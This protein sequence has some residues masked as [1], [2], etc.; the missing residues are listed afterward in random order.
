MVG[1]KAAKSLYHKGS[2]A[3][4]TL[5][6]SSQADKIKG[7]HGNDVLIG[8]GG[9]DMLTGGRGADTFKY[10]SFSD[11]RGARL[12]LI[13]DFDAREGDKVDLR[14]LGTATLQPSYNAALSTLQAVF[15]YDA[16][17]NRTTL[18]YYQGSSTPVFQVQFKGEVRY[19]A[20]A[21]LGIVRPVG[22]T[23]QGD[24]LT[25]TA[26]NDV[27]DLLG[28]NDTYDGLAGNDTIRGGGGN[29][30]LKGGDNNDTIFG[31]A[32]NDTIVG[33]RHGDDLY[34]GTGADRFVHQ[35][36]ADSAPFLDSSP[37]IDRIYD[38]NSAEGDKIDLTALA[39]NGFYLGDSFRLDLFTTG[40]GQIILTD[41]GDGTYLLRIFLPGDV[42]EDM[43]VVLNTR[44]TASDFLG[45]ENAPPP[46]PTEGDDNLTGTSGND[47][48][49]LL[50]GNDTYDGLAGNDDIRGGSG[51]DVLSGDD[52]NDAI[53]GGDDVDRLYGGNG[54]DT[55]FGDDPRTTGNGADLLDGGAGNDQLN[56]WYGD[57]TLLGG[58][59]DDDLFG[60]EGSDVLTGGAGADT[61]SFN[62]LNDAGD[63]DTVT[64]F[65]RAEGDKIDTWASR[66]DRFQNL[67]WVLVDGAFSQAADA[68]HTAG[69]IVQVANS[70][71]TY[72]LSFYYSN[73][74][75]SSF[76]VVVNTKLAP[77][78]FQ[79]EGWVQY[80]ANPT[81]GADSFIGFN[82]D[83]QI[84][85]LGGDDT[86][87][88][89]SGV[90]QING[91]A[92]NDTLRAGGPIGT[93]IGGSRIDGGSGNDLLTAG[94]GQDTLSGGDDADTLNGGGGDDALDGGNGSDKLYGDDGDDT[95][96]GGDR[97]TSSSAD[98]ADLLDGGAG[99]DQLNGWYGDDTLL[100]GAGNDVL[101]GSFDADTLTGGAGAD[102]FFY[103]S[104]I[105]GDDVILDFSR[106]QGDKIDFSGNDSNLNGRDGITS[107]WFAGDSY[108]PDLQ[109]TGQGQIV[110]TANS[111]GTYTFSAYYAF[112]TTPDIQTIV[113]TKI[114]AEDFLG[115]T[116]AAAPAS[117]MGLVF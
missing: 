88:G 17:T 13:T 29:D 18:S 31:G 15:T 32:G 111:N 78:D 14:P 70:D 108:R 46:A 66:V 45:V 59:G 5:T 7:K 23:E 53:D 86:Y 112:S 79:R 58:A 54:D 82:G 81:E 116:N 110:V 30:L 22:P 19:S 48:I 28:G 16:A 64:D 8:L 55:L 38:F 10:L 41:N 43:Q 91:G 73:E 101:N 1:F 114:E 61:F 93:N 87:D 80:L 94:Y 105:E 49:D 69:Q 100:G 67:G 97:I 76:E 20:E 107:W 25:G 84:D 83:D 62:W 92:G 72:T 85:L 2:K 3:S 42:R 60:F 95:L 21:F 33:G 113:N 34:G 104:P 89:L 35:D 106:A 74:T 71:G 65:N 68:R 115:V 24:N 99:D 51:D 75:S 9:G 90:D 63:V 39:P 77:S 44:V 11:S 12:D 36:R 4:D 96:F 50:G 98:T 26:G 109:S 117:A 40:K 56:G 103:G 6:G 47:T 102:I 27:I 57:D 52:G 37:G